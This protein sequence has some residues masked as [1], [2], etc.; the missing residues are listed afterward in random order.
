MRNAH[1]LELQQL[2]KRQ[3]SLSRHG[4]SRASLCAGAYY[5]LQFLCRPKGL[6]QNGPSEPDLH[7]TPSV[8][9][10]YLYSCRK[11]LNSFKTPGRHVT[12]KLL[13]GQDNENLIVSRGVRNNQDTLRIVSQTT[14][15]LIAHEGPIPAITILALKIKPAAD[16]WELVKTNINIDFLGVT[17][18]V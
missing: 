11:V 2:L 10:P 6:V 13:M 9:I 15:R 5:N 3:K 7:I 17:S 18:A 8:E 14:L 4:H 1:Y 12:S 16:S